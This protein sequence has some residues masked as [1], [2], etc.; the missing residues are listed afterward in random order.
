MATSSPFSNR[1]F[2]WWRDRL[3]PALALGAMAGGLWWTRPAHHL[4]YTAPGSMLRTQSCLSNLERIAQSFAQ[5]A[6]DYDGKFPRGVDPEDRE[7][8]QTWQQHER[9]NYYN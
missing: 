7:F 5:Y 1:Q 8:P 3:V 9:G 4:N 6:Q 2:S